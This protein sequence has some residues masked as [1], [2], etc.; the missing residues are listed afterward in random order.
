MNETLFFFHSIFFKL[1]LI[2]KDCIGHF[3]G[4]HMGLGKLGDTLVSHLLQD[5]KVLGSYLDKEVKLIELL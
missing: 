2:N 3:K 5:L 1:V 4:L